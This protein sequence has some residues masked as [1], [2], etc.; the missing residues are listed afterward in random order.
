MREREKQKRCTAIVLAA[1]K[2]SRMGTSVAKQYLE[3]GGKPV[4]VHALEAFDN[5]PEISE[6]LLMTG[7]GQEAYCRHEIVE[8]YGI[9]KVSAIAE[10]GKERYETVWKALLLLK[11]LEEK[12][13]EK[14]EYVFIHD[15]ARPFID[16]DIICRAYEKVQKCDACVVGM[17]VKDTIKILDQEGNII[18]SP[19][20]ELV[21]QAQTPQVFQKNLI[22]RAFE[23]MMR[24]PIALITDD[25]MVVEKETGT[26]V[27]M[28]LG[29]YE[30]IKIT[31][32][33]DLE[34]AESFLKRRAENKM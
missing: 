6:I 24:H 26:R 9:Q 2:G 3:I 21:W 30:N 28:V 17:P 20:R 23:K 32:P 8:K 7:K 12:R 16:H 25:A 27:Q 10:G 18:E 33:E 31:T 4:V 29:S 5:A 19:Q 13:Q 14:T 11:D 15:G 1:G 34:I 22:T